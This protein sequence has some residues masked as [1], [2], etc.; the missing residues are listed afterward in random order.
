[1]SDPPDQHDARP[2][3]QAPHQARLADAL[4]SG[5][6]AVA[7]LVTKDALLDSGLP[8]VVFV[9]AYALSSHLTA[10]VVAAVGAGLVLATIRILRRAPLQNVLAGFAGVVVCAVFAQRTGRAETFYLPGLVTNVAY[11]VAY[12]TS[13]L[14]RWPLIGIVVGVVT[15]EGTAWRRRP[16]LVRAYALAS[17]FWVAL[18]GL[19]LAVQVPLY[20]TG[21]TVALG[22]A[23]VAMGWPLFLLAAWG[24]WL[25]VRNA[26][27]EEGELEELREA[28][29][30]ADPVT[31]D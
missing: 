2:A 16:E 14:V 18:F 23:R 7:D 15:G 26:R 21:H 5:R 4:A 17:W 24:S 12:L 31:E 11:L 22:T 29:A 13:I 27:E 30:G 20:L 6:F 9:T 8:G 19:R 1:V 3:D 10:S 25:V 28:A